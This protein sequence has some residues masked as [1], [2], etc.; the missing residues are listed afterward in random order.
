MKDNQPQTALEEEL[1][2]Y[3]YFT[4]DPSYNLWILKKL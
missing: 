2:D 1:R 4:D 3:I